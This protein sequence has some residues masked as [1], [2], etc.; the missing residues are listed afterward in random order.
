MLRRILFELAGVFVPAAQK[1]EYL[2]ELDP[3]AGVLPETA[4]ELAIA[5]KH[6]LSQSRD[7]ASLRL[8]RSSR[9]RSRRGIRRASRQH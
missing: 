1:T 8:A 7:S 5:S 2:L 3:R 6:D 4:D 9:R